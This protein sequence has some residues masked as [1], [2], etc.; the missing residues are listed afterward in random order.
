MSK[1][2]DVYDALNS[3]IQD[4]GALDI[5][6][7]ANNP[8]ATNPLRPLLTVLN[9]FGIKASYTFTA[10]APTLGNN[11]VSLSGS[12][13]YGQPGAPDDRKYDVTINLGYVDRGDSQ[14]F[15]LTFIFNGNTWTFSGFFNNLPQSR[16]LIVNNN[17]VNDVV[18]WTDSYLKN[19]A[20]HSLRFTADTNSSTLQASGFLP[21]N[22]VF[23]P[24]EAFVFPWPLSLSGT[25]TLPATWT[26]YPLMEL[27]AL[28]GPGSDMSLFN[29]MPAGSANGGPSGLSLTGV[30]LQLSIING[31]DAT[32]WNRTAFSTLYLVGNLS[33]G[34]L[35]ARLSAPL[36]TSQSVW[37]LSAIFDQEHSLVTG[38]AQ[39]TQLFGMPSLPLPDNFPLLSLFRFRDMEIYVK[40]PAQRGESASLFNLALSIVSKEKWNTPL[41]F[42]WF[43]DVG[44]RWVWA[45]STYTEASGQEVSKSM[46][47]GS[48]FGTINFG[49]D[50]DDP[51]NTDNTPRGPRPQNT[52]DDRTWNASEEVAVLVTEDQDSPDNTVSIDVSLSLP[53]LYIGGKMREGDYIPISDALKF[54]FGNKGPTLPEMN[55]TA[56]NF[57]ADP[58][59][60]NYSA[61]ATILFGDPTHP[62][63]GWPINLL[64]L[65]VTLKELEFYIN[66]NH[67]AVSGGISGTFYL[68]QDD[69]ED[70]TLP[71]LL[72]SADYKNADDKK[73]WMLSGYLYPGTSIDL[74]KLV[75]KFIYGEHGKVPDWVPHIMVDSLSAVFTT[76]LLTGKADNDGAKS[77]YEFAGT[78]SM[79]WNPTIFGTT[80]NIRTSVTVDIK[81]PSDS[82]EVSGSLTGSFSVNKL[83][84]TA[85]LT[86]GVEQP[87][88]LFKVQFD[89]LWLMATT[90][91]RKDKGKD[92]SHQVVSVQLGG[93][94][95]GDILEYLV[96][97]A[98]PTL[99]FKLDSP[100]DALKK[101]DLSRFVLTIDPK[102]NVVE[103][104][105]NTNV[106]L[107]VA[108]LDSIGVRYTR[109][110]EGKVELILTGSFLGQKYNSDKPLSW[111]V[112]NDPPPSVPGKGESLLDLRFLGIGQRVTFDST[113]ITTVAGSIDK[114]KGLM[115]KPQEDKFPMPDSMTYSSESQWL[116]ALDLQL[117]ETV[118][119]AIIFNDP[120]LYGLSIALSG[121]RAG[122]LAGL[123]FE[124][125][126][127][128]I[129]N[130][131]GMFRIE[132]QVPDMF[133]T[134]QL[135]A[136][137]LTLGIVVI[138]IY[139][140]GNFKI[141]L[142]FPYNRNFDRSFSL[143]AGIFIGRGGFYLGVLN[144]D[145]STQ[146]PRITNGNFSPVIE[147]GVG[148]AAGIGREIKAGILSGGAFVELEV[149]FQG[150]LA[151][152]NPNSSGASPATFF[153][154]Q[155]I[156]ALHGKVYGSVDFVVI[157]VSV[158]LEAYA[159]IS[160]IYE[161]YQPT[162][163]E[164]T[165]DVSAEASI[166]ILFITIHFSFN[167]N[168]DLKFTV[169]SAEP[170]PWILDSSGGGGARNNGGL[171]KH[172]VPARSRAGHQ[173]RLQVLHQAHMADHYRR[174]AAIDGKAETVSSDAYQLEWHPEI[175]IFSDSPQKAHMTLLP[176]FTVGNVPVNWNATIPENPSPLYR[177]AFVLFADTGISAAAQTARDCK[178][179]NAALSAMTASDTDTSQLAADILVQNLLLYVIRALP[180]IASQ[181]NS[182]TAAQIV[183]LLEQLDRPE[184]MAQGLSINDLAI[185]FETNITLWISGDP[186][187]TPS[188]KG[189]MAVA[190]PP[191]LQWTS[192]QGGNV[193]FSQKNK[194]GADYERIIAARMDQYFP[195][196]DSAGSGSQDDPASYESFASFLFRDFCLM[197]MKSGL[198]EMQKLMNG[199]SVTVKEAD[200][201]IQSLDQVA[202]TLPTVTIQYS[203][204]SGDTIDSVAE[205]LGATVEELDFLNADLRDKL[206]HDNVGTIVDVV[207]GIAPEILALDNPNVSLVKQAYSLGTLVYQAPLNSTLRSVA[208]NFSITDIA[209]L[210]RYADP[211]LPVLS[212]SAGVLLPA[213]TFD[214]QAQP[215]SGAPSDFDQ[216]RTAAVFFMRYT[217]ASLPE[218]SPLP[219]TAH[220]YAQAIAEL[221]ADELPGY[222][223]DPTGLITVELIPGKTLQVPRNYP[224][225]S[226]QNIYTTVSGDTLAR[227][228]YALALQQDYSTASEKEVP[229][230]LTFKAGV[231]SAGSN[232]WQ[233]PAKTA[234][235]IEYGETIEKLVRRLI[236][237]A[238][239]ITIGQPVPAQGKWMYDWTFVAG[240]IAD[241]PIIAP[242]APVTVPDVTTDATKVFTF[243]TLS[244]TYGLSI[245]EAASRLKD[246]NGLF[247]KDT[248]LTVKYLPAQDIGKLMAALLADHLA[249]VVNQSSRMFLSGLQ[250]PAL[251]NEGGHVVPDPDLSLPLYDLTGQ[252]FSL[253]VDGDKPTDPA[254]ALS[255]SSEKDW[256]KLLSS[257]TVTAGQTLAELE[258]LYPELL[259][260]N[261]GLN[262]STF[263][264][265]MILLTAPASTLNY[266]YTNA[267]VLAEGPATGLS[268]VTKPADLPHPLPLPLS[269]TVPR[270]YGLNYRTEL[271]SPLP[272]AIPT[273]GKT[274]LNGQP[275]LWMFPQELLLKAQARVSTLYEIFHADEEDT[276]G[277]QATQLDNSTFG[278]LLP[279]RV[280]RLDD[281]DSQFTLIGVDTDQ[282]DLLLTARD[283]LTSHTTPASSVYLLLS[284]APNASNTSGLTVLNIKA[285]DAVLIKSNLSTESVPPPPLLHAVSK[286]TPSDPVYDATLASLPDFLLLLWEGSVVGG[287]GY[288]FNCGQK[289]SAS[290]FDEHGAATLQ[291]LLIAGTQQGEASSGRSLLPF[292]NCA[293]LSSALDSSY[294][295]L[296]IQSAG[297]TS[298]A[299]TITRA[300]VPPGS[301]G[302][303]LTTRAPAGTDLKEKQLQKLYSLLVFSVAKTETS[304]FF[305]KES[306]MPVLASPSDGQSRKQ[307]WQRI[308]EKRLA[309][310]KGLQKENNTV[311]EYGYY[312]QVLPVSRFVLPS[313]KPAATDVKG[314]PL[315]EDDPYYGFG[316][317][318]ALPIASFVFGF[319]DVLG[320]RTAAPDSGQGQTDIPVGYTDELI[321]IAEWPAA[322][323]YFEV[324]DLTGGEALLR[325]NI[326]P[327]PSELLPSPSQNGEAHKS[328]NEQAAQKYSQ[329]YYQLIQSGLS[330]WI[331][332]T[333]KFVDDGSGANKGQQVSDLSPLWKFA[334]GAYASACTIGQLASARPQNAGTVKDVTDFYGVRYTELA[335]ANADMVLH[336]LFGAALPVVP[337]YYPFVEHQSIIGLIGLLPKGWPLPAATDV[338]SSTENIILPLK[339]GAALEIPL[340]TVST[341][342]L[343]PTSSLAL[344]AEGAYSDVTLIVDDN[345]D[346]PILQDGFEFS[347]DV[348]DD[349]KMVVTV[350]SDAN[351]FTAIVNKYAGEGVHITAAGLAELHKDKPGLLAA[352][353]VLDVNYY[354]ARNGD[355]LQHNNSQTSVSDLATRNTTTPDLFDPGAL[356]YMGNF[357]GLAAADNELTLQQLARR[358]ACPPELL[359]GANKTLSLVPGNPLVLPGTLAWPSVTATLRVPYMLRAT[360]TL[361]GIAANFITADGT[362]SAELRLAQANLKMP[363][364]FL[365]NIT[366]PVQVGGISYNVNTGA[367][368]SM[369]SLLAS[370][371]KQ[372]HDA[373]LQDLVTAISTRPTTLN[374]GA[375]FLCPPARLPADSKADDIMNLYGIS[376]S[377]F[378]LANTA[379][380]DLILK[381]KTLYS[382]D[383]NS[384]IT[385]Q[386]RDTFNTLITRFADQNVQVD[387]SDIVSADKNKEVVFLKAQALGLLPPSPVA[388][389]VN[390]GTGG[391]YQNPVMPLQTM[392]Q[393]KRPTALIHPDFAASPGA[394]AEIGSAI[395][396][397][398]KGAD[399]STG[400][401]FDDFVAEMKVALPLLRL[402][403]GKVKN[404]TQDLF[405]VNFDSN[406]IASVALTGA[407]TT[408]GLQQP[409]F[410]ALKPLYHYLVTQTVNVAA[411]ENG[412]LPDTTTPI[413][414]QSIDVE[415][416]ARRFVEDMD[417]F[418]SGP[419]A[420][421][422]YS[423]A[424]TKA[425]LLSALRSKNTLLPLIAGDME[426][427]L[428]PSQQTGKHEEEATTSP[429]QSARDA[430]QQQLGISLAKAY[431]S[432]VMIQ[433]NSTVSSAWQKPGSTLL[434][435][436]LYGEGS[437]SGIAASTTMIAAKTHLANAADYVNFLLTVDNPALSGTITGQFGY[438]YSHVEFN[439][440]PGGMPDN[441]TAS[442]WLTFIPLQ[443]KSEKPPAL[444]NTDP[445]SVAVPVPLRVFPG[446]PI[447]MGQSA[448]QKSA[449]PE[450]L[451]QLGLWTYALT[452]SH[453]HA[454]Q[455]YAKITVE[456]NLSLPTKF[457]ETLTEADLF[458]ELAQY[459]WVAISL[460]NDL[461]GLVSTDADIPVPAKNAAA[462]FAD[463]ADRIS[464][465]WAKR[466]PQ[467]SMKAHKL[468]R[469]VSTMPYNFNA[470]ADYSE[471]YLISL[472]L[473]R[474]QDS[475]GP[476]GW[477]DVYLQRPDG[478]FERLTRD[479][480]IT[481]SSMIYEVTGAP[482]E[483]TAWP[484]FRIE[485][486]SL[487]VARVQNAR[488]KLWVERNQD[489]VEGMKTNNDFVLS[490][491]TVVAPSVVT[492]LNSGGRFVINSMGGTLA[493]AL[494]KTFEAL[495]GKDDV[496]GQLVTLELSYGFELVNGSEELVTY[497]PI[498]LYPNQTLAENT[499]QMLSD[500]VDKWNR[501]YNPSTLGGEW[502]FSLKQ[503]SKLTSQAQVLLAID[504]L[505][506]RI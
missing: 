221:N 235:P 218:D 283:W 382:P 112:I 352:D 354:I 234:V 120:K 76:G 346:K 58:I 138:E 350:T 105:F 317:Q 121:E 448:E 342:T 10:N 47:T 279:F 260:Y 394:V 475:A 86:F 433:Y 184:T 362:G 38:I 9:L 90:S 33:L 29:N 360:D 427:L 125:L 247:A 77:S 490:T 300:V 261:P 338:L 190:M 412:S 478:S 466:N 98:A 106:D 245:S 397:P 168:L 403:T 288:Y 213:S 472:T 451:D 236:A 506:Y 1:A 114:L 155:G 255:L 285:A 297:D 327:K 78:V 263:R 151:W 52:N 210:L 202:E 348:D 230:W 211:D 363:A 326:L 150:V 6:T 358:Y 113:D 207:L 147:L 258:A 55:V 390:I 259:T 359:L 498:G 474:L 116:I 62:G 377:S 89:Q 378:A 139:T 128:K 396:A 18:D 206:A 177:S 238:S 144:G 481:G 480:E 208:D 426:E 134:I 229:G 386:E 219:E 404:I 99:G 227:I 413:S 269:G 292:N 493:E 351:S 304:P 504:H 93:V 453:Q 274:A 232:A 24:Y 286:N 97:L 331:V 254:L 301:V 309:K 171:R 148:I 131:I 145:T 435:A 46:I 241:A 224:N 199:S 156:V 244:K 470:R 122:S 473:T 465:V 53:S 240:W 69:P 196:G 468:D 117:M 419:Y 366:I 445:G 189:V 312:E 387:A 157:K 266:A 71:R 477:P 320:N 50:T 425:S 347:V 374:A 410:F 418:L 482:F 356:I 2:S 455:D 104:V 13:R 361:S 341:G 369:A 59:G 391:P 370:L 398:A 278:M 11:I 103:F 127:K 159:Q 488:F 456:F 200:E 379:T 264:T 408:A 385:T 364:V 420:L 289:I 170:T 15:T 452:Y 130:D 497:L 173:R 332:S 21:Q 242:L 174:L 143:Q 7:A 233:I 215:F 449:D 51:E 316:T 501:A 222:F 101:I 141:D 441:Y 409:R 416:W 262:E 115:T 43:T 84:L 271:Q 68:D 502:V 198:K 44:T 191:F 16:R 256:I 303:E 253:N 399:K 123:R 27:L 17:G 337:A 142:G 180:A 70:Y 3:A 205:S 335:Q 503:Y 325:I 458:S 96:N 495:F 423:A 172:R 5:W 314:L 20:I 454:S 124:I 284:P 237:S 109:N 35:T 57:S 225:K 323:R 162:L 476:N 389:S 282:R 158:T 365:P 45:W 63:D 100:W 496:N 257:I 295:S 471:V 322:S 310:A 66:V 220:W 126:Y 65:T 135:G 272:L 186:G 239:W 479:E 459:N 355:T 252:Q 187:S 136:V 494:Q 339:A 64:I 19:V 280:K 405:F 209:S 388:L 108:R 500:I 28:A 185:F 48:V 74:T 277:S 429:V 345:A 153:K 95:L 231:T 42:V 30:G 88:Y 447:L 204:Q 437:I 165:V 181:N 91:W 276:T 154:C 152:F 461:S 311:A 228:G 201:E 243:D 250:L 436:N 161:S 421:A 129:T 457:N 246:V 149:I 307:P 132:F 298:P 87:V 291:L 483:A 367:D 22:D 415:A 434:P 226:P 375:L 336:D 443:K 137:S 107:V 34:T 160:V 417:R 395:P 371:Q 290:A 402:A 442:D 12:G 357:A 94:T 318:S 49:D 296:F 294:R 193:D 491:D 273:D 164:L 36:L 212:A 330:A 178:K 194:I 400:L 460:W 175:K 407:N 333:L 31:L 467:N 216:L 249:S 463:L 315:P 411:L 183:L 192:P 56:L 462:T 324:M 344:L 373:T 329:S 485:W 79:G 489:L 376:A 119:L 340:R 110:G 293:L 73:G 72:I 166:D 223:T 384:S 302:F 349:V 268:V 334:A 8:P 440:S 439:I 23:S 40:L 383:G 182:I 499:G 422:L 428:I 111:D 270:T 275:S 299:E 14:V 372:A 446:L 484:V 4:G 313:V 118:D 414:F 75:F 80:F 469:L 353:K 163:F 26:D 406:G 380:P 265:G 195:F 102:E 37:A 41:P 167:V 306:G 85:S 179:R 438:S 32:I 368:A 60:Q 39:L 487:N 54:F 492:P 393:I 486:A 25:L 464:K 67:G 392:L 321:G 82:N 92:T 319:G 217:N 424:E 287:S 248:E 308:R 83:S 430:L 381:D 343:L 444:L 281:N 146:V 188:P 140:N 431:E 401:T 61:G 328:S 432:T 267:Q 305:A 251:K 505:V 214:M 81:K 133:R 169:G 176:V 197:I 450:T 203:I